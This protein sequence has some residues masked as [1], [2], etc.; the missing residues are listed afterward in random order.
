M[1][2]GMALHAIGKDCAGGLIMECREVA[3]ALQAVL[4]GCRLLE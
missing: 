1:H 3:V 2:L 4:L